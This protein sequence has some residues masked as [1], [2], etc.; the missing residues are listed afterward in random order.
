MGTISSDFF[1]RRMEVLGKRVMM[2]IWDSSGKERF[3]TLNA[4]YYQDAQGIFLV[5]DIAH[6]GSFKGAGWKI[7]SSLSNYY[8]LANRLRYSIIL[9]SVCR[10]AC[11]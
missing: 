2:D 8:I 4:L 3:R 5:Y 7:L 11:S 1:I 9:A 6:E 10:S